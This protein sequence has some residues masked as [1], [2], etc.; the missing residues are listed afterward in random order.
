M[1]S[2]SQSLCQIPKNHSTEVDKKLSTIY[3][4]LYYRYDILTLMDLFDKNQIEKMYE[5]H[6]MT[7]RQQIQ[8]LPFLP[9]K[10]RF[11]IGRKG[12]LTTW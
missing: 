12:I 4:I 7:K 9:V 10:K 8:A 6:Q 11:E 5:K 2:I 1:I 3:G